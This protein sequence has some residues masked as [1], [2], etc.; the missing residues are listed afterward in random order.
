MVIRLKIIHLYSLLSSFLKSQGVK[1]A[2]TF[3]SL[4]HGKVLRVCCVVVGFCQ[5]TCAFPLTSSSAPAILC[6]KV[7][8]NDRKIQNSSAFSFVFCSHNS[9][10]HYRCKSTR[11]SNILKGLWW[12]LKEKQ[13]LWI[14]SG[15]FKYINKKSVCKK[16]FVAS[17]CFIFRHGNLFAC[18]HLH[19]SDGNDCLYVV[20]FVLV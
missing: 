19:T 2:I 15:S 14:L 16:S 5:D 11:R 7:K 9:F 13:I 12:R 8:L 6:L 3:A 20:R 18:L 10:S 1:L 4:N 17:S